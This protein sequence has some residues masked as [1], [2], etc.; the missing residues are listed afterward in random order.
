MSILR[1]G[2]IKFN[3]DLCFTNNVTHPAT[4]ETMSVTP[5]NNEHSIWTGPKFLPYFMARARKTM[6]G[7]YGEV[8]KN[9]PILG[10]RICWYVSR[11][12]ACFSG[13]FL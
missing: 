6:E 10:Y 9:V 11:C 13:H 4:G 7:L 2:T 3:C 8:A 12:S 5:S 1:D